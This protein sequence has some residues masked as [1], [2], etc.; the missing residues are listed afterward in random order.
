M[1]LKAAVF[2]LL[3]CHCIYKTHES[4]S[5]PTGDA[6]EYV[7]IT[8][9]F[10]RHQSPDI[11]DKDV[12]LFRSEFT[13]KNTWDKVY[14]PYVFDDFEKFLSVPN[15]EFAKPGDSFGGLYVAKNGKVYGYHFF[16]YSLINVPARWLMDILEQNPL[17]GFKITNSFLI[18][19][20]CSLLLFF[21]PFRTIST[22]LIVLS[23]YFSSVFWYLW[24][25]HPEVFTICFVTMSSWLFFQNRYYLSIILMAIAVTQ[26]QP[27]IFILIVFAFQTMR[28]NGLTI[29][30][31]GKVLLCCSVVLIPPFF[32]YYH[33]DTFSIIN[34]AGYLDSQFRTLNRILG[35]YFDPD[36]GMI[37]AI[38]L[39]LIFYVIVLFR[40]IYYSIKR[41]EI[42][43]LD[44]YFFL[45]IILIAYTV[46]GMVV[47]NHSQSVLNRYATWTSALVLI[48]FFFLL[49]ESSKKTV[50][51]FLLFTGIAQVSTAFYHEKISN[52]EVS[53]FEHKPITKWLLNNYPEFYSPDPMIFG[54]RT[55]HDFKVD[56][57]T[58]PILYYNK[59]HSVAKIMCFADSLNVLRSLGISPEEINEIKDRKSPV[60]GWIYINRKDLDPALSP[61]DLYNS[62]RYITA[63]KLIIPNIRL[64]AEQYSLAKERSTQTGLP[65][66][67]ILVEEAYELLNL[68]EQNDN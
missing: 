34:K 36:Q 26:N 22:C 49:K 31:I 35:F 30:V 5:F 32:Y 4:I 44:T 28:N 50:F 40:K 41:K 3:S 20:T 53:C 7:L 39:A 58:S 54:I 25:I 60:G 11:R 38:P 16:T 64:N 59:K 55:Q 68:R 48:H 65:V 1:I 24:W 19:L 37:L 42:P 23:F 6:G 56:A 45:A 10:Y 8:E 2:L 33:F 9:A 21:T 18:I 47:W 66:D 15:K 46:S 51:I 17:S 52:S 29:S 67:S 12:H 62:A 43:F 61:S 57:E 13:K 14:K 63:K 27:L